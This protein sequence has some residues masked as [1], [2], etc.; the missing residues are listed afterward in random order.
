MCLIHA[1]K[2]LWWVR[3]TCQS[4]STWSKQRPWD[5]IYL[6]FAAYCEL[7]WNSNALTLKLRSGFR[8]TLRKFNNYIIMPRHVKYF[9]NM[10]RFLFNYGNFI[11]ERSSP[12]IRNVPN[13]N[14]NSIDEMQIMPWDHKKS[15]IK[16]SFLSAERT[17]TS[18]TVNC[19][20]IYKC[21][22][23]IIKKK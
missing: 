17:M 14:Q 21:H 22:K 9:R 7:I 10:L 18:M 5:R 8:N 6:I 4:T 16:M 1:I 13:L 15:L 2:R 19:M 3:T 11:S 12:Y 23:R 20:C